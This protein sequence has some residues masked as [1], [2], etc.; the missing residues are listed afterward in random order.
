MP[1]TV[2]LC[3]DAPSPNRRGK[4][5]SLSA[6]G[7]KPN[8]RLETDD[9]GRRILKS[10]PSVGADLIEVATYVFAADQVTRRGGQTAS[11]LATDWRRDFRFIS[12][13]RNPN[14]WNDPE[15]RSSLERLLGF[16]SDD[17]FR[18]EFVAARDPPP[19]IE[20]L[21]FG[22]VG[23]EVLLFSGGLDSLAGAI[24]RLSDASARLLL[25][26]H[27]S[28][29]KT[30]HRQKLLAGELSRRFPNRI[31]HVPARIRLI[32]IEPV[33]STQ[34]TRSFLFGALAGAV[35]HVL[36]APGFSLFEN[37]I[38]SFN[39]PIA[40][41]VVGAAAT[42][43]THPRV[44]RDLSGF[45]SALLGAEMDVQN[46]F[47]WKTKSEVAARL[48]ELRQADLARHTVSCSSIYWSTRMKPHCGCCS[49]CLDRRFGALA[50]GLGD[51]D[52]AEMYEVDLLTGARE[53]E[54]DPAMAES[55]VR[56][57]LE[58]YDLTER[59]FMGRFAGEVAR[60]SASVS[61]LRPDQVA[62]AML[63]LHHRHAVAVKKV[64]ADGFRTYADDL[65]QQSLPNSCILRLV[66]GKE[67]LAMPLLSDQPSG[68]V[69]EFDTR[70]FHRTHQ[71]RIAVDHQRKRLLVAGIPPVE[72]RGILRLAETLIQ[73]AQRDRGEGRAPESFTF[74]KSRTLSMTL[75]KNEATLR[76]TVHR[77]RS[78]LRAAFET[79]AGLPLSM[80]A[81]VETDQWHGYRLN[82]SVLVL[83]AS[84]IEP[85]H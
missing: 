44:L 3:G 19:T 27:V 32:R 1:E 11:R 85:T 13:V 10:L 35:A 40:S 73:Q 26:S 53:R 23:G 54:T 57:A 81:L 80:Y 72:G 84:E 82:P 69:A 43:T 25:V 38:V 16:M 33:E 2:V 28:S 37:G 78:R 65:A 63:D 36:G 75:G 64:L 74:L 8:I 77:V 56:H 17:S 61:S 52:P 66:A 71:L 30:G 62:E 12:P 51:H 21:D 31:V 42:R 45:L 49:Q 50:G 41:Q 7:A 83:A 79:N 29:T 76:R 59:T 39:L 6:S 24:E 4:V 14:R 18:F 34:R 58:L 20:Y 60:A 15:V 67:G 70:D 22:G 9:L 5:L 46:P 47:L 48:L 68:L 55:F